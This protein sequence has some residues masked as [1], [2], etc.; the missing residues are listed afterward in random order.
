MG[1]QSHFKKGI[2]S[3]T[4][5]HIISWLKSCPLDNMFRELICYEL[6]W[7]IYVFTFNKW[8]LF[9][10]CLSYLNL[11][12]SWSLCRFF[13]LAS[14]WEFCFTFNCQF[15]RLSLKLLSLSRCILQLPCMFR[16]FFSY[17]VL[18]V[19]QFPTRTWRALHWMYGIG[20]IH[21]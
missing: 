8:R 7:V 16:L 5:Y 11:V 10:L 21:L 15:Y 3:H 9:Q 6:V 1:K 20:W 14:F 17:R 4:G 19:K 13:F 18:S 12:K 2:I